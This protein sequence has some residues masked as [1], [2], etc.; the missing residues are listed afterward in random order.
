MKKISAFL[1][2]C[3]VVS[4]ALTACGSGDS[5]SA[6]SPSSSRGSS[7]SVSGSSSAGNGLNIPANRTKQ[8]K[9]YNRVEDVPD[10]K[11][12]HNAQDAKELLKDGLSWISSGPNDIFGDNCFSDGEWLYIQAFFTDAAGNKQSDN[13]RWY[14][15]NYEYPS[16]SYILPSLADNHMFTDIDNGVLLLEDGSGYCTVVHRWISNERF[17]ET[18][19]VTFTNDPISFLGEVKVQMPQ[20]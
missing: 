2:C 13:Y 15:L 8:L 19:A 6:S 1:V 18:N 7:S 11:I 3:M 9:T 10:Y 17:P 16:Y 14:A 4:L 20:K 5:S 12:A